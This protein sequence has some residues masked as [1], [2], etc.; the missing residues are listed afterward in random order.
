MADLRIALQSCNNSLRMDVV[1]E[2]KINE[3]QA[4]YLATLQ[5]RSYVTLGATI[6]RFVTFLFKSYTAT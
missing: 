5:Q 3:V 6:R 2:L 1:S 4:E